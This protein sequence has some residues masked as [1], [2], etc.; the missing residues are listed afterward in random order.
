M[1][2]DLTIAGRR[3][4]DDEPC[5][6]LAE[7]GHNHGGSVRTAQ[8][9]IR[10]AASCGVDAIKLQ[11][12][13]VDTL[14]SPAML[15]RPYDNEYGY[16]LTYGAHRRALEFEAE[17]YQLCIATAK[18]EGVAWL[19]TAFDEPS[20][21]VLMRLQVPAIK[22]ASGG[23]TDQPLLS[24][25]A[26]LGVPVI[27]STGG[28][29][30]ADIDRAVQTVTARTTRLAVLHSTA[31]YPVRDYREHNLRCILT[32]RARYPD[33]VVGWSGH[34][35]GI[36][37]AQVAYAFGAR[38]LEMHFTLDRTSKGTDHAFSLEPVGLKKLVRDLGRAHLAL[39]DGV[40]RFYLSER[41]PISKMRRGDVQGRWQIGTTE[42]Q[43]QKAHV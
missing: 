2:T 32:L 28:G 3:I 20:A 4:A 12:R 30:A 25:V 40:K 37:L 42:E 17:Q 7:L 35:S 39:G 13:E 14:Y 29:D 8:Q 31:A 1:M 22:I 27:L 24:Y 23:L 9:M 41:A 11:K 26:S 36:A 19:A 33:L 21:D 18:A 5:Y 38:I 16:G 34:D 10:M 6:V 43:Q 15:A